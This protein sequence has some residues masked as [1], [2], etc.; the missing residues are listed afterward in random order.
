M[1]V[2][3]NPIPT[4][5]LIAYNIRRGA[6]VG[7]RVDLPLIASRATR[8][9]PTSSYCNLAHRCLTTAAARPRNPRGKSHD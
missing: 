6:S 2:K 8:Y 9:A 7:E 5:H 3:G 4:L 1:D